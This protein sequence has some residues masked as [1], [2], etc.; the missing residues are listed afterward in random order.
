MRISYEA[1]SDVLHFVFADTGVYSHETEGGIRAEYDSEGRLA[2]VHVPNAMATASGT[3]IF[4]QLVFDGIDPFTA[5]HP[6]ILVP[7]LFKDVQSLE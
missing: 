5:D 3:D 1:K 6:L 4:R 7:R 2:A